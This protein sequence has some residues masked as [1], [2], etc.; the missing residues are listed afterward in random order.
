[1]AL[2]DV[3]IWWEEELRNKKELLLV[4][5]SMCR[6]AVPNHSPTLDGSCLELDTRVFYL[7]H[8]CKHIF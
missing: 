8:M 6:V 5:G 2:L 1:M 4:F 7:I 3:W